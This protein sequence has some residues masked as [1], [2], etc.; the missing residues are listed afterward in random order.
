MLVWINLIAYQIVWFVT[1]IGASHGLSWPAWAAAGLLWIG[2][3]TTSSHKAL[4]LKLLVFA[5]A[6]GICVDG[7]LAAAALLHYFPAAPA[8]PARGC[9][10]WILGLWMAFSTT[11]TR[12]LGWLRGRL[13]AAWML[14]VTGG[15][16]AYWAAARGWDV[17][18]FEQ[19]QWRGMLAVAVGWSMA[20]TI[21][22]RAAGGTI[23]SANHSSALNGKANLP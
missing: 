10:L 23:L 14:G 7:F 20:L 21:L 3:F 16:L 4:D 9:P 8:V 1:V 2:H 6:C 18:V 13:G 11:L 5:A 19:P 15:P 17:I 22:V 12:S